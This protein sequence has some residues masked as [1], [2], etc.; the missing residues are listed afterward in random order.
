MLFGVR[1]LGIRRLLE[2]INSEKIQHAVEPGLRDEMRA[3]FKDDVALLGRLLQ[4]DL[5]ETWGW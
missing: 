3:Y 5:F 2:G 1:S 4:R